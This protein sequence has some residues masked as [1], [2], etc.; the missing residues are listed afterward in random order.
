MKRLEII[1]IFSIEV[2]LI[3][4]CTAGTAF[5]INSTDNKSNSVR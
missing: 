2:L 3:L 5:G 4:Y 1:V